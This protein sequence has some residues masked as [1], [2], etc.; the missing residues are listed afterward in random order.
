MDVSCPRCDAVYEFDLQRLRGGAVTLKC[1]Q[2]DHHFRLEGPGTTLD[3]RQSRWMVRQSESGDVL[4]FSGFDALHRW[5][6]E[7]KVS[8]QDELSRTG[9]SWRVLQEI[10]EFAPIFQVMESIAHLRDSSQ[11]DLPPAGKQKLRRENHSTIPGTPGSAQVE[12]TPR[13]RAP[14]REEQ[15]TVPGRPGVMERTTSMVS[16]ESAAPSQAPPVRQATEIAEQHQIHARP[17]LKERRLPMTS[18]PIVAGVKGIQG[19]RSEERVEP[20]EPLP[21]EPRKEEWSLGELELPPEEFAQIVEKRK[22]GVGFLPVLLLLVALLASLGYWQREQVLQWVDELGLLGADMEAISEGELEISVDTTPQHEALGLIREAREL[23]RVAALAPLY[24]AGIEEAQALVWRGVSQ[25]LE[26]A[27]RQARPSVPELLRGG[28]RSLDRGDGATALLRYQA[29][30]DEQ[31]G[32][33][34]ALVGLGWAYLAVGNL[35]MAVARFESVIRTHPV[36]AG[37]ALIGLGRAERER[38]NPAGA[39]RAYEEYLRRFPGGNQA[40]IAEF[41]SRQLRESL[42]P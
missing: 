12:S 9:N 16:T 4:Y 7:G 22:R 15:S 5:I 28:Q 24:D 40:S 26:A 30:L 38:Q 2:C 29:V 20:V 21:E 37:D 23:S 31:P 3:E 41:Q 36:V 42:R 19:V 10:G 1:S 6:M 18:A 35:D 27:A 11:Q 33:V 8:G 34:E 39:L 14:A 13:K 17:D 32:N 25:G